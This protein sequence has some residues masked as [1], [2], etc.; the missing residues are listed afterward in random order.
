[1][2][3]ILIYTTGYCGFCHR[4]KALLDQLGLEYDEIAVDSDPAQRKAMMERSGRRTV[5]QIFIGDQHLGGCDDLFA[6][7]ADG[8]LNELLAA[9]S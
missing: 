5:P 8:R 2:K 7:K 4:A 1:M 3:N 6:A 9:G